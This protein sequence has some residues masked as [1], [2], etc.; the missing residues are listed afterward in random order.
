ML[1]RLIRMR[2][3]IPGAVLVIVL[4]LVGVTV[5]T[6]SSGGDD[7]T[8]V[9][10]NG[11]SHYGD[12]QVFDD[13]TEATGIEVEIRGGTAPELFERLRREGGDTPADVLITTDL[14]NLWRAEDAGLLQEAGSATLEEHVPADLHDPDGAW[15]ASQVIDLM[16]ERMGKGDFYI[17]CPD[18]EVSSEMDALR[19]KWA[20]GDIAENRPP[21]SRWHPDYQDAFAEFAK[22]GGT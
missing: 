3:P 19:I 7:D 22:R 13:F 1:S 2:W 20:A 4:L 6:T 10:Y 5:L 12:E 16:F 18:N 11:R 14:A 8:L 21:L 9:I 17:I 15:W